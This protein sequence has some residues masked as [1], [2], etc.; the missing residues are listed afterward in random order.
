MEVS[1]DFNDNKISVGDEVLVPKPNPTD[2]HKK[3]F[4]GR[5]NQFRNNGSA[6]V[7]NEEG[8]SFDFAPN[9]L[10]SIKFF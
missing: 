7:I 3:E 1:I 9:R 6:V 8:E 2:L 4:V 5:I 10:E